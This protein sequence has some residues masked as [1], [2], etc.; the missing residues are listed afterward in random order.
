MT[1]EESEVYK[2]RH[3]HQLNDGHEFQLIQT[4]FMGALIRYCWYLGKRKMSELN[5]PR[6]RRKNAYLVNILAVLLLIGVF[7]MLYFLS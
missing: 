4:A 3:H 6:E 2:D 7:G 1:D 5:H